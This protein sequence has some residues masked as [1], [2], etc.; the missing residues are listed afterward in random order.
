M[1][2]A[3]PEAWLMTP[4]IVG[5]VWWWYRRRRPAINYSDL[6][7][8]GGQVGRRPSWVRWGGFFGRLVAGLALVA[9]CAGP[10]R[11]DERTRL[12]AEGIAIMMVLDVSGSMNEPLT[13]T[14]GADTL[15]R[16]EAARRAFLLFVFGGT[17]D[18][19][20]DF[21]GRPADAIGLVT[22][23]AIPRTVCPLTFNHASVLRQQVERLEPKAGVD[24]G[25]N[26]GDAIAEGLIRLQAASSQRRVLILLSD[27][28]HTHITDDNLRPR[29]AAQLAA[30][31]G[32]PI[33]TI[34]SAG[35]PGPDSPEEIRRHREI[36]RQTLQDIAAMTGGQYFAAT[37]GAAL[38]QAFRQLDA[39]E[40]SPMTTFLYRRYY[41]YYP[42]PLATAGLILLG[43]LLLET[44]RWRTMP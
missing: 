28:E 3:Y 2:F 13:W 14:D 6:Q 12:P 27:G 34:D 24:A 19:G 32:V 17:S 33:Y 44:T 21:P 41:E 30:N 9:A 11:P 10:R 38:R 16:L 43:V 20:V 35:E 18:D 39:L 37:D 29:Q 25:T 7:L 40:R 15:T 23:A 22:F 42:Y 4:L 26:I 8:F 31:L 1:Q 5:A 36:G